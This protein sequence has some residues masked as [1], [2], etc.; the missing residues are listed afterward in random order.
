M[1]LFKNEFF[2]ITEQNEKIYIRTLKKGFPIKDFDNIIRTLP[3]MKISNFNL[4]KNVLSKESSDLIE[5]GHLLPSIEIQVSKDRMTANLYAFDQLD[6]MENNRENFKKKVKELLEQQN[7]T[8]GI[9]EIDFDNIIVGKPYVIAEGTPPIKGED[10][11]IKYLEIPERKPVI[12]E[13]GRADYF[14]MNFIFE[15]KKDD[16]LGEKILPTDGIDG[17]NI[18]GETIP[19]TRGRDFPIKYDRKSA[20]EVEEDGK[21]VIRAKE[22]GVVEQ[23][24]DLLIVNRHLPI[25]GNIG[26]ETGN[27]KFDGSVTVRGTVQPGFSIVAGGDISIEGA[28]GVTDAKLIK[29]IDGDVYIRGGIFGLGRTK[30]EAGGNIFVKHVNEANLVAKKDIVIGVYAIGSNLRANSILVDERK[31]KIIGGTAIAKDTI[32]SAISGN[33]LERRTELIINTI[34]RQEAYELVQQKA[35]TLKEIQEEIIK[36]TSQVDRL[37]EF[38]DRLNEEQL[39]IYKKTKVLLESKIKEAEILDVE[40]KDI[41]N[42]MKNAGKQEIHITKEAHPG[43]FLQIGKKSKLLSKLTQGRFRIEHGEFNV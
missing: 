11:K 14:D 31:G 16:W 38:V 35:A 4:L 29:S 30:V 3:R 2:E 33:R 8:Y 34:N 28:E 12:R 21:I 5:I 42:E 6:L 37:S 13:D 36:L 18:F 39:E 40:I 27:I 10:A 17:T 7:I 9:K 32:V 43:T 20:Y 41:L 26:V 15:I 24:H 19:A 23:R 1:T 22:T 25:N